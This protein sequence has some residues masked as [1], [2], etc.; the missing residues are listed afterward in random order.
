MYHHKSHFFRL[1]ETVK[2][3]R[4]EGGCP[5][6]KRQTTVSL[7]KYLQSEFDELLAAINN[8][9]NANLCEELGDLLFIIILIS[10]INSEEN[11]FSIENVLEGITEKLIRRHPHV[12]GDKQDL[13]EEALRRQWQEIKAMEKAKKLI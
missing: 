6:D 3:L 2:T 4:G 12:F 10:E 13:D 7:V 1:I 9:D 5:W 11:T 8:D